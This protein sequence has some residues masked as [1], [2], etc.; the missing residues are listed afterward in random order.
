[1]FEP[2]FLLHV[3]LSFLIGGAV[4]GSMTV[5]AQYLPQ[6]TAGIILS[7]PITIGISLFFLWFISP[8]DEFIASF[9]I[10]PMG[11]SIVI[12][13]L[14][15]Y[16]YVAQLFKK[17]SIGIFFSLSSIYISWLLFVISTVSLG[18]PTLLSSFL[19]FFFIIAFCQWALFRL[20]FQPDQDHSHT[21]STKEIIV[22]MVLAGSV[23]AL[24]ILTAKATSPFWGTF[25]G[26]TLP[27]VYPSY[28][29][30]LHYAHGPSFLIKVLRLMPTGS[31]TYI[32]YAFVVRETYPLL[33]PWIGTLIAYASTVVYM[34]LLSKITIAVDNAFNTYS[35]PIFKAVRK[36]RS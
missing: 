10:I 28:L 5:L 1:M 8:Q 3:G 25:V 32:V 27:S 9:D 21:P 35:L 14:V 4:I 31:T 23:V 26:V 12:L 7:L 36:K 24:S 11:V 19:A 18:K 17:R 33:G 6:K 2:F 13:F 34:Y 16:I 29:A 15:I 22:R 20:P 30:M